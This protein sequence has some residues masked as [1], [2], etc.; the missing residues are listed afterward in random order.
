MVDPEDLWTFG[1]WLGLPGQHMRKLC[2]L[3]GTIA[4]VGLIGGSWTTGVRAHARESRLR[5]IAIAGSLWRP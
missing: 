4:V 1:A 2:Y 3:L 5:L